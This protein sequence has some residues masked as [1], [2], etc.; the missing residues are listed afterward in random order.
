L[1]ERLGG[2]VRGTRDPGV[3]RWRSS[4]H[5]A[6][7]GRELSAAGWALHPIDGRGLT[8]PDRLFDA[9]ARRLCVPAWFRHTW[10]ALGNCLIDLSWLPAG[11]HVVL[12]DRYG[13]LAHTDAKAWQEAYRVCT[14]AIAT[15]QRYGFPPLYVLLRGSGPAEPP[16]L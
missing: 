9:F 5:P 2:V 3:Y 1:V 8:S 4:A 14:T 15:R 13:T 6:A 10:D 7:L 12:W 11:G 16:L